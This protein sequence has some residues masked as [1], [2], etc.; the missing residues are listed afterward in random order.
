VRSGTRLSIL[1]LRVTVVANVT[2]VDATRV[3]A[4]ARCFLA[5]AE[6]EVVANVQKWKLALGS[7]RDWVGLA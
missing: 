6:I 1:D 3:D 5:S 2:H 4:C 7:P